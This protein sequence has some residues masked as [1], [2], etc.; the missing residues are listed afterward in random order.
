MQFAALCQYFIVF[1]ES[2]IDYFNEKQVHIP[3][4]NCFTFSMQ[5]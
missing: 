5:I 2:I 4:N 3:Q 1:L